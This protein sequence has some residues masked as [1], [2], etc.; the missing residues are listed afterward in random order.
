MGIKYTKEIIK[1][2]GRRL[3]AGGP[4]DQQRRI[5]ESKDQ[6]SLIIALKNEITHLRGITAPGQSVIDKNLFTGEQVDSEIRK[7]VTE[8]LIVKEGEFRIKID[9]L[10]E[11]LENEKAKNIKLTAELSFFEKLID[12]KENNLKL[13]IERNS[14]LMTQLSA[15]AGEGAIYADSGRPQIERTFIDPLEKDSGEYLRPHIESEKLKGTEKEKIY[16]NVN[17]LK[18]LMNKLP[19]K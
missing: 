18:E 3:T 9:K 5:Q 19:T 16:S 17:K 12:E 10:N 2:D 4:R 8:A 7:A 15:P 6:E 11:S 14:Q 13:E 1:S